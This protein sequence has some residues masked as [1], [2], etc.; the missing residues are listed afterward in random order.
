MFDRWRRRPMCCECGLRRGEIVWAKRGRKIL[1]ICEPCYVAFDYNQFFFQSLTFKA[2]G[3]RE[4][5]DHR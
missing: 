2:G 4:S 3:T 1:W 5:R